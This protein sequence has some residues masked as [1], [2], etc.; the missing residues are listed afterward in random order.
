MSI[1]MHVFFRGKLPSKAALT[2]AMKELGFPLSIT[3]KGSLEQQKGFMPMRLNREETGVEFDVFEGRET[4]D[5]AVQDL[6]VD[7]RFDRSANFRWGGDETEMAC[8]VC[9]GAALAKLVD[10]VFF[11]TEEGRLLMPDEAIGMAKETLKSVVKPEPIK[12]PGTRPADIKR[13]LKPLLE[14]R[15]DLVLVGRL[16][17]VRPVRHLLRGALLRRTSDKYGFRLWRYLN[18]LYCFGGDVGYDD[19]LNDAPFK[20]WQPHFEPLLLNTLAHDI[21]DN[22]GR[23]TTLAD[24][25]ALSFD[26]T[27]FLTAKVTSLVLAGERDQ[28]AAYVREIES[29]DEFNGHAQSVVADQWARLQQDIESVCEEFHAEEK[30]AV[31]ALKLTDVWEPS[32]FPVELLAAQRASRAAEEPVFRV[33]PWPDTPLWLLDEPPEAP[34]EVRFAK[35]WLFRDGSLRLLIPLTPDQAAERHR[36][37]E[38]YALFA[39]ARDGVLIVIR[40]LGRDKNEPSP[41]RA[42][43]ASPEL[44]QQLWCRASLYVDL[45]CT[46]VRVIV[47]LDNSEQEDGSIQLQFFSVIERRTDRSLWHCSIDDEG[48]MRVHDSRPSDIADA[49]PPRSS[50]ASAQQQLL[51][52]PTPA[53][54]E[55]ADLAARVRSFLQSAGYGEI[56]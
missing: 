24:F 25:A 11:D 27:N 45:F 3:S 38:D 34:G 6:A 2:R 8:G 41:A 51:T 30:R 5:E 16:L 44:A 52:C 13:Y 47:G 7:P 49:R 39:R 48:E 28:A 54:G 36:D 23:I 56:G 32:P 53:F 35:D 21:F 19:H 55:Y 29:S 9:A 31:E 18:P 37:N 42:E 12:E 43:S 1:E 26:K 22:L 10:G 40:R 20:V 15:G 17:V 33:I 50:L 46:L 4:I 14:L